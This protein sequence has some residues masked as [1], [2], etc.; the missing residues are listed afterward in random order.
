MTYD[1]WDIRPQIHILTNYITVNDVVNACLSVGATAIGGDALCE[2]A[3]I[4]GSCDGL[5]INTGTPSFERLKVFL[6]SGKRANE[7]GIPIVL[8]PVG[9]GATDFRRDMLKEL[10]KE[11][12]F[13]CIRGNASEIKALCEITGIVKGDSDEQPFSGVEETATFLSEKELI[14]LSKSTGAVIVASGSRVIIADAASDTYME[15]PG[16]SSMQKLFTG[17]GCMMTAIIGSYLGAAGKEDEKDDY[18]NAIRAAVSVYQINAARAELF[19]QKENRL[20]TVTYKNALIDQLSLTRLKARERFGRLDT[21]L[22]AITNREVLK[23]GIGLTDA[24]EQAILGGATMIQLREKNMSTTEYIKAAISINKIC[25]NYDIP[26]IINDNVEVCRVVGA[27][28]VHLGLEDESVEKARKILGR[29]FIIG[30]TAHNLQEAQ[31]AFLQGA[32]YLGVGAA[33]GSDTKKDAKPMMNL[34]TYKE[35]TS[36][37]PIPVVAI[38]GITGDNLHHLSGLGLSGIAVISSIFGASDIKENT[39][40]LKQKAKEEILK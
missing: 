15:L 1:L 14:K 2:C 10:L 35:I 27:A 33:F 8:D 26:L 36:N 9:A 17:A 24:V 6:S 28:G 7:L 38:G 31:K 3:Q 39:K 22:Y 40:S 32:D 18:V 20:G 25:E 21:F 16:G 34:E 19:C 13:T 4:T 11:V 29:D 37:V 5:V 30:A 23:A 12:H